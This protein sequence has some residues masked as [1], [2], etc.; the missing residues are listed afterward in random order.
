M[1]QQQYHYLWFSDFG[2][3]SETKQNNFSQTK[4]LVSS[5]ML[6]IETFLGDEG[7]Q[8]LIFMSLYF[9]KTTSVGANFGICGSA[10]I[11]GMGKNQSN[12]PTNPGTFLQI[13]CC[14]IKIW[15]ESEVCRCENNERERRDLS[16]LK[17]LFGFL[18]TSRSCCNPH[19]KWC[20][21]WMILNCWF[22]ENKFVIFGKVWVRLLEKFPK[23][24]LFRHFRLWSFQSLS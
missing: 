1:P 5:R 2:N 20:V 10:R 19:H 7:L 18:A 3:F 9:I 12:S 16:L 8:S 21:Y 24:P 13:E 22:E 15:W 4:Q 17:S 23:Q 6:S 11:W 14:Q